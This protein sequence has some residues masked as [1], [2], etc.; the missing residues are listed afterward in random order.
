MKVSIKN[1]EDIAVI[2]H[3]T[4]FKWT[5]PRTFEYG[6]KIESWVEYKWKKFLVLKRLILIRAFNLSLM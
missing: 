2:K 5:N 4:Y 1:L 3:V 6:V